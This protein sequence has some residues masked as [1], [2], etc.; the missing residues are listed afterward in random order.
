MNY[1]KII[2][3]LIIISI[4]FFAEGQENK[5]YL[6]CDQLKKGEFE[7]YSGNARIHIIRNDIIQIEKS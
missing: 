5:Q 4:S 7:M 2:F 1:T 6:K 3:F